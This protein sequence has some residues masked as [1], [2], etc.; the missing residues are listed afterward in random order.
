MEEV[1][2]DVEAGGEVS[3][4]FEDSYEELTELEVS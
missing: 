4:V 3:Q 1:F 2:T